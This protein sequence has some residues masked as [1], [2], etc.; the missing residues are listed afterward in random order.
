MSVAV[1]TDSTA[2]LP[3]ELIEGYGIDVVPLYVV[4]AG[5]SG[6]EGSDIG[7]DDVAR[8]LAVARPDGLDLAADAR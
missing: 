8:A 3:A 4:L 5:R 1:V 6:R 2:Y 7:P